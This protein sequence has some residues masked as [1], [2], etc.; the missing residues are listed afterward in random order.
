MSEILK[1]DD[2]VALG[3]FEERPADEPVHQIVGVES[4]EDLSLLRQIAEEDGLT[5]EEP[6]EPEILPGLLVL[7]IVGAAGAVA[8]AIDY[9]REKRKGGQVIDLSKT[10][11]DER[12][13]RV[14]GLQYGL[15]VVIAAD[16][17]GVTVDVKEPRGFFA[18]IVTDVINALAG[19]AKEPTDK[20]IE[21]VKEAVGS[22]A[23]VRPEIPAAARA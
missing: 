10:N 4:E 12:F 21:A 20:V 7:V 14:K 2:L 6:P 23:N 9:C 8:G 13:R 18:Q 17:R 3:V 15:V 11:D 22:R 16:G 19:R 5:V 1:L